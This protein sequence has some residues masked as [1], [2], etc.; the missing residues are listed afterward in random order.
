MAR[1]T[2][3]QTNFTAGEVSPK[4]YGRVDL[5]RYQNGARAMPNCKINIHGGAE[6]RDGTVYVAETKNSAARC[7][8]IPYVFSTTQAYVL[9]FGNL[10]M[11]VYVQSGGQVLSGGL[12]YEIVTPYTTAMLDE[13]DYTQGAD[14]MFL[15]HRDVPVHTLK[16]NASDQWSLNPA[17]FTVEPFDEIGHTFPYDLT[18]LGAGVGSWGATTTTFTF[19]P[20]DKGRRITYQNGVAVIDTVFSGTSINITTTAAFPTTVLPASQWQ[21]LDSP[22]S[23]MTPAFKDPVGAVTALTSPTNSWRAQDVGKFVRINGGLIQ[24][25]QWSNVNSVNGVIKQELASVVAAPPSAWTLEASVWNAIN[26]YP[27]TGTLYEQ[28]LILAGSNAYPQTVW[29]SRSGL[30][31]DFTIGTNDDDAFSFSLPSTGQINPIQRMIS[32]NALIPLTYGGEHTMQGGND[33][34]LTPTNVKARTPSAYGCNKVKPVRIGSEILFVQRAGRKIRALAYRLES[35]AYNAPDLTVLAEHITESGVT[36]MAYQQEPLPVLWCVRADGKIATMTL[37]RDEGVTAW[38]PL[39]TDGL[40]ES[41]AA[42]PNE[43][44]DEVWVAVQ[45]TI[46]GAT[47]RY[48]ERFDSTRY[49]DCGIEGTSGPGA[50]VWGNLG[51]LEGEQVAVKAD[52]VYLGLF[53]VAGAQ[54]TLPRDAFEVEIGVLF[55]NSVTLLRPEVQA[56]DGTAQGNAQRVH[57]ISVLI[58]NSVGMKINGDEVAFREFGTELLDEAPGIFSGYKRAGLVQWVRDDE[59]EITITQDEP[60]PFHVLSVVRKLTV[61]P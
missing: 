37:D 43:T 59:Q 23:D 52:G 46:N 39:N 8:L 51:H 12:P 34:P 2:I 58:M 60:Y 47:K 20:G 24:I 33:L 4:C 9:E 21:L 1:V 13:L 16:R 7:R 22:Q 19:L 10:Y 26:G 57:E 6:R 28:R 14:T 17:P 48:V 25:T 54:V 3:N 36:D 18:L 38:T 42:I 44:G 40:F 53:T 27:S 11:R 32:A 50:S 49:T 55:S 61:N 15:C 56:G 31:Y 30:F 5:T 35:D 29:G 45:R 41:V